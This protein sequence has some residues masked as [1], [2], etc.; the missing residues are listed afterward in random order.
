MPCFSPK[1]LYSSTVAWNNSSYFWQAHPNS[2]EFSLLWTG[3]H[4]KPYVLRGLTEYQKV[5]HFP[6]SYEITRKDRLYR[7]V[8]RMQQ[9]KVGNCQQG[10]IWSSVWPIFDC[11][12]PISVLL[13]MCR[14]LLVLLI[15]S[16]IPVSS[17]LLISSRY[18]QRGPTNEFGHSFLFFIFW[19]CISLLCLWS[20]NLYILVIESQTFL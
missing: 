13:I 2:N 14:Y 5:N 20:I 6:R 9:I 1:I 8:Q 15:N 4:L 10:S 17:R 18:I 19:K 12:L 7:N 11:F 3:S 16:G